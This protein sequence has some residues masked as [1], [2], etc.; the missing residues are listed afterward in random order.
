MTPRLH[1]VE[2]ED[3]A[4]WPTVVRDLATDYLHFMES[5]FALHR[6]VVPLLEAALRETGARQ[7]VDLCSGGA[8]PVPDLL[9]D[10]RTAGLDVHAVL[11][12]LYPNRAAFE[13]AAATSGGT[14]TF[15]A[16][17][18]DARSVPS[19][20]AG[21]RTM[22]NS[23][24]HFRP[25][26]AQAVLGDAARAGQP[27]G[28][29]EIPERSLRAV[30]PF[31]FTPLFVLLATPFIRPFHWQRL[32]WTYLLPLVPFTCWWDGLVSQLRAYTAPE[33]EAHGTAAS[34]QYEWHAGRVPIG[35]LPGYLTYLIGYDRAR[36]QEALGPPA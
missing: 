26:A 13:R 5:R 25:D 3:L 21:F 1:L 10:L 4:W 30:V 22:F 17:P 24:H 6:P 36:H 34:R 27:I 9:A 16:A 8:G 15:E 12:D 32:V 28:I 7:L 11:T 35:A 18:V 33:L 31:L 29:F 2:L 14:I 20:L 19:H 23:F